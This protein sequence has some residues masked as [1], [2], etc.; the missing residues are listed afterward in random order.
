ML[1]WLSLHEECILVIEFWNNEMKV[2]MVSLYSG[3]GFK[4]NSGSNYSKCPYSKIIDNNWEKCDD[5]TIV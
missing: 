1:T 4:A 2:Y 5:C 3:T